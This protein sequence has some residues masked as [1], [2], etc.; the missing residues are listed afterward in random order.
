MRNVVIGK[1]GKVAINDQR[2]YRYYKEK[3]R[4]RNNEN[5]YTHADYSKIITSFYRKVSRDLI[6]KPGGVFLKNLGYF[7]IL[8]H[9]KKQVVK[10]P[11][12]NGKEFFNN[13]TKNYL[14]TP[15]FF[16]FGVGRTLLKYW[17]MDRT[18]SKLHVK[19]K[20][21]K[22]LMAGKT[23]KT[24]VATLFSLYTFNTKK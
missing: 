24:F 4:Y 21:H 9:P 14:W 3:A 20:L 7:T 6:E 15:S 17:V 10:V 2:A 23:Y 1:K 8:K 16:G 5:T 18:F 13:K 19:E 22:K 11:Y 12:L